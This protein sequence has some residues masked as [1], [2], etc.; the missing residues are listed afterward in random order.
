VVASLLGLAIL[1]F[2]PRPLIVDAAPVV[3]GSLQVTIDEEGET[4]AHDRFVIA[5]PITGRLLRLDLHDGDPVDADQ[6]LAR[7]APLPLSEREREEQQARVAGA[8]ALRREADERLRHA[9]SDYEQAQRESQRS[10][11]LLKKRL[12]ATQD[13]EQARNAEITSRNELEAARFRAKAA[14]SDVQI[15]R[16]GLLALETNLKNPARLIEV[17]SPVRGQVLRVLEKSERVVGA[18]TALL[19]VGDPQQ[20]EVVIDV[21]SSDAVKVRPGMTVWLENWG[22]DRPLKA[23]VRVVEPY[24]FTKVSA[25]GIEEQRVNIVADF[26]DPPEALGDGYRVDARIVIWEQAKVLKLPVSAVF[27]FGQ[28]WAVFAIEGGRAKRRVITL[29]HRGAFEVEVLAGIAEQTPVITHPSNDLDEG[30]RVVSK[31]APSK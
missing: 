22:G 25:L 5:A 11:E 12:I 13:A 21:L 9:Q 31:P 28:D 15:A 20:L 18:G 8:E 24:A 26:V 29:G 19:N 30:T 1:V 3:R 23:R 6:V 14:T 27:R 10:T 16:A 7:I 2:R 17:R 4:R